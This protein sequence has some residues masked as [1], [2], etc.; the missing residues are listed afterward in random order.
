MTRI[1]GNRKCVSQ[2]RNHHSAV[3]TLAT[4]AFKGF[5]SDQP[6][7]AVMPVMRPVDPVGTVQTETTLQK[8]KE[9]FAVL[10]CLS[11][12]FDL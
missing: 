8:R 9:N 10:N 11:P 7:L 4:G 2:A 3:P 5:R 6:V 1:G 12:L